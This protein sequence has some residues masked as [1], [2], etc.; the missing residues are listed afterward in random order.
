MREEDRRGKAGRREADDPWAV[1][2]RRS[3]AVEEPLDVALLSREPFPILEVRNPLHRT[4]YRVM[5]PA[6][7]DRT[8]ALCTCT[9]FARRGLGTC[10]H[11]EAGGRW[12][13]RHPS[14]PAASP[15]AALDPALVWAEIDRRLGLREEGK[16][17]ESL[18]LRLPGDALAGAVGAPYLPR[19]EKK[20]GVGRGTKGRPT[21]SSPSRGRP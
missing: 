18:R 4:V 3:R 10:K 17:P 1:A 13:E 2:E 8:I 9:D 16:R 19:E 14:A 15:I 5:L 7:P 11:I 20:E 21:R 6:F 12:L